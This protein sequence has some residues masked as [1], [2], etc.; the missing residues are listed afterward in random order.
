ML[1]G[2]IVIQP[3]QGN[4]EVELKSGLIH[5]WTGGMFIPRATLAHAVDVIQDYGRQKE[6]YAPDITDA[7]VRSRNGNDFDVYMR[8]V[9]SRFLITDVLD[10]E[11]EIHFA[12]LSATRMYCRSYSSRI[13][14]VS[15]AG[16]P[17]EHELPVGNDRGLLWR[18]DGYWFMEE[19]DGGVYIEY[20]SVTLSR[21]IPFG[22]GMVLGPILHE[23]PA[24]ALRSSLE[25]TRRAVLIG[26][27]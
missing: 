10:T 23:L 3:G 26:H 7:Q 21:A 12:P 9:K 18:M 14:E 17:H 20:E 8:I 4:G 27:S 5:D 25:K 19:R 13:A 22:M 2:S 24:E 16:T 1:T 6:F 15:D 11:H